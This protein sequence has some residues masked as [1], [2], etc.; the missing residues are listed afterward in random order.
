MTRSFSFVIAGVGVGASIFAAPRESREGRAHDFARDS[1]RGPA[2]AAVAASRTD[3]AHAHGDG[4]LPAAFVAV[5]GRVTL[6]GADG[7]GSR[8]VSNA[9]VYLEPI[10]PPRAAPA[11]ARPAADTARTVPPQLAALNPAPRDTVRALWDAVRE[12]R[13]TVV[14]LRETLRQLRVQMA[15][16][17]PAPVAG[18][19]PSTTA[20]STTAPATAAAQG[21]GVPPNA[22]AAQVV[23]TPA[24]ARVIPTATMA[25]RQKEFLPHVRVVEV[26]GQVEYPNR[27]PFSHNVFSSTPGGAFDLGL[28]PKGETRGAVFR[29]PGAYPIFC[30]IHAKMS[31]FVVAVPTAYYA[32]PSEDGRFTIDG[33]PPG[34]YRL[35]AWHERSP[36]QTSLVTVGEGAAA[37]LAV[38]LDARTFRPAGHLN[39][40]GQPYPAQSRDDY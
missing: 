28:Y 31:A 4:D 30:N 34:R 13:Q 14:E 10:T 20:P 7:R 40:F 23:T 21:T 27:D 38:T 9:V 17:S 26:G 24:R 11:P 29:R 1:A 22:A 39:K 12:L 25:M 8:D 35:H 16:G 36:E 3:A 33:V 37:N 19:T 18:A 2:L 32:M 15:G 5:S 6:L